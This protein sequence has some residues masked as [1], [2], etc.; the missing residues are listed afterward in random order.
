M[1]SDYPARGDTTMNISNIR[2]I[3]L[4]SL[5][6]AFG[7]H[8]APPATDD[9]YTSPGKPGH[10]IQVT[11]DWQGKASVGVELPVNVRIHSGFPLR[12]VQVSA[13]TSSGLMLHSEPLHYFQAFGR[14]QLQKTGDT[15]PRRRN[16]EEIAMKVSPAGEGMH[17]LTVQVQARH[18]DQLWTREV[19]LKLPVGENV[20]VEKP[21][22]Q[23]I[24]KT[25]EAADG[26]REQRV[27]GEQTIERR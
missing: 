7:A 1:N 26:V 15:V 16:A 19:T 18:G 4:G 13:T 12:D 25:V 5:L 23:T 8:A 21:A 11:F 20:V 6:L 14:Q 10:P 2:F 22:P 24:G 17:E 27:R 3:L 9:A